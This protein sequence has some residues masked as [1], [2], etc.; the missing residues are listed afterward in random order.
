MEALTLERFRVLGG[1]GLAG[2]LLLLAADLLLVYSPIPAPQFNVFTAAVGKS[3]ARLV[4]GSLLGVF[5]IPLVLASFGHIFLAL[6]P[7]GAWAAGPPVVLGVFAYVTGAGFHTAIPLY[8]TA[9]QAENARDASASPL[10]KRMGKVFIPLQKALFALVA[11]SSV[12][13]LASIL[14]GK[15]LYPRWM[16]IVSPLPVLAAFRL[17]MR[18][19]SPSVVGVLFPAGNNLAM[20][21][22][23]CC[24]LFAVGGT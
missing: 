24:S 13:L 7:G 20:M 8:I 9:I 23:V 10:L 6:Q 2:S 4:A 22:F 3:E 11:A 14:S 5:A 12:C 21:V 15:T 19:A 18:L 16:A 17:A 1:I